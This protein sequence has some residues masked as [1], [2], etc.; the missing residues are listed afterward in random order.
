MCPWN[1][2]QLRTGTAALRETS[3]ARSVAKHNGG[4]SGGVMRWGFQGA[5]GQAAADAETERARVTR[6][7]DLVKSGEIDAAR[8]LTGPQDFD[9]LRGFGTMFHKAGDHR[10]AIISRRLCWE[11]DRDNVWTPVELYRQLRLGGRDEEAAALVRE[12]NFRIFDHTK[13]TEYM[14]FTE[15]EREA[16]VDAI[17]LIAQTPAAA[18]SLLRAV[19]YVIDSNISGDFLECGVYRGASPILIAKALKRR[20]ITDRKIYMYDTYEGMP[21]PTQHDVYYTGARMLDKW[22]EVKREGSVGST[23]MY[24][25]MDEVRSN[26]SRADYPIENFIMIKGKVEDTIPGVIP[27]RI[28]LMRLDT[29]YYTSTK[30]E[31]EHLYP[32]LER[33]GVLFI[34]DYGA[35]AGSRQATDEYLK[36]NGL[37]PMLFRVNESVRMM[38]KT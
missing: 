27:D 22:D 25:T 24:S 13:S 5:R 11:A 34:D 16:Y 18:V 2:Q 6:L 7:H 31:F 8:K 10:S 15:F 32:R 30:H 21:E 35:F 29:D 36:R 38:L 1:R 20:G 3:C 33:G 23:E 28:C 4:G 26:L 17:D 19:D 14:D 37:T 9:T 12:I